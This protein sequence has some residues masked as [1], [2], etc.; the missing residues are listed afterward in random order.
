MKKNVMAARCLLFVPGDRPDRFDPA[1]RASPDGII[2]DLED[3]VPTSGKDEARSN[4]LRLLGER[5]AG[6]ATGE[7]TPILVRINALGTRAGLQDLLCLGD[8]LARADAIVLPKVETPRDVTLLQEHLGSAAIPILALIETAAGIENAN[9]IAAALRPGDALGLGGADLAADLGVALAWEPLLLARSLLV[10]AA[11]NRLA[12]FDVPVLN[13]AAGQELAD[14][15]ARARSLGYTGKLAIHPDQV[16]PIRSVFAPSVDEIGRARA[17]LS[18][19][20][21]AGVTSL[22]GQMIDAPVAAMARH[23]LQRAGLAS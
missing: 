23:T 10:L 11:R 9:A 1:L 20:N 5:A 8:G 4:V 15:A 13:R 3:A 14:E 19:W 16:A 22:D 6:A 17:V 12:L 18:A 7:D 21:G 2:L